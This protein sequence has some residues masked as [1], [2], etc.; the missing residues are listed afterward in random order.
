MSARRRLAARSLD[1]R[2]RAWLTGS[3]A[4]SLLARVAVTVGALSAAEEGVARA[5]VSALAFGALLSA[6]SFARLWAASRARGALLEITTRGLLAPPTDPRGELDPARVTAGLFAAEHLLLVAAP[7]VLVDGAAIVVTS[8]LAATALPSRTLAV[9]ALALLVAATL[10]L[11]IRGVAARASDAAWRSFAPVAR[12]LET[13]LAGRDELV[14]GGRDAHLLTRARESARRYVAAARAS[15]VLSS[16]AGRIPTVAAA[17]S[18]AGAVAL[19]ARDGRAPMSVLADAVVVAS[20]LPALAGLAQGWMS[21]VRDAP[22]VDEL[23]ARV[24]DVR[25]LPARVDAREV[26]LERVAYRYAGAGVDALWELSLRVGPGRVVA[27]QGPNGSGKSTALAVLAGLVPPARGVVALDGREVDPRAR[28]PRAF[29]L[30]SPAFVEED[31]TVGGAFELSGAAGDSARDDALAL[32]GLGDRLA[33]EGLSTP[34][35]ALSLGQR[36]RLGL[37][38]AVASDAPLVL[39]DEPEASLDATGL[40]VVV[41]ALAALRRRGAAVVLA[42]HAPAVLALA[43]QIVTLTAPAARTSAPEGGGG[44]PLASR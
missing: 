43:D 42:S 26:S 27:L 21:W 40:S 19:A 2:A 24:L 16:L 14:A 36:Q 29:L 28:S 15:D 13:A 22:M 12:D 25:P 23:A 37:A 32:V 11:S 30:R 17:L 34:T 7:A 1:G 4:L 33:A 3:M 6:G 9:G 8:A 10:S 41:D 38:R 39:L 18:V 31:A 44:E 5:A 35:A 20:L